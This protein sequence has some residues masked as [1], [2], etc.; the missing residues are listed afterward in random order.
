MSA[1]FQRASIFRLVTHSG[2]RFD[3]FCQELEFNRV[4]HVQLE[5]Q[6]DVAGWI[7]TAGNKEFRPQGD[8]H[9]HRSVG[10][11]QAFHGFNHIFRLLG[12]KRFENCLDG[13]SVAKGH[14]LAMRQ[15]I[16]VKA[17]YCPFG[18]AVEPVF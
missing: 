4:R 7:Q 17:L 13:L 9:R 1:R 15:L 6:D 2:Q 5:G 10:T 12:Y 3:S 18:R 14:F 11:R 8:I 16:A